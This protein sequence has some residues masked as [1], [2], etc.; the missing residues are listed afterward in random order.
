M[1]PVLVKDIR[2]I[3]I[4]KWNK[5]E[6]VTRKTLARP[7]LAPYSNTGLRWG[8]MKVTLAHAAPCFDA[9]MEMG[10]S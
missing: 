10:K 1:M 6:Q 8:H 9:S 5:S 3:H 4:S 2:I 7:V